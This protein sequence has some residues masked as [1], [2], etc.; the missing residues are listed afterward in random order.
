MKNPDIRC[1]CLLALALMLP[2]L[3]PGAVLATTVRMH[4]TL[5]DI[6][7]QLMDTS[8]PATVANFLNYVSAG[9]YSN[10]FIH[11]GIPGFIVQGGGFRW[12]D[13]TT[14]VS[15]IPANL[16]VINEYSAARSNLRGT[17]AMAKLG[18]DPNSATN[19]WFFNLADN[20]ANLDS[21][22]G[23]F[24]V[25]G[26][27]SGNG[28]QVVDA[29][30]ALPV[31][32]AGGNFANLPLA[33]TPTGGAIS[34][35]NLVMI[36]GISV[37]PEPPGNA[38]SVVGGWNL[39]GNG[40]SDPIAVAN[41]FGDSSLVSTVWKWIPSGSTWAFYSPSLGDGGAAYATSKGYAF[42][43]TINAGEGFWV[44]AKGGFAVQ[45]SGSPVQT[46]S[47]A[48]RVSGNALPAGWSLIAA[49]A[50]LPPL[51]FANTIARTPPSAGT[52]VAT[53]LASLWTWDAAQSGWYFFAPSLVNA[54]TQANYITSKG[55]LDFG[56]KT[57]TPT[58]GFWVNHP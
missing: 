12:D 21:Q 20:A 34:G 46:S 10:T 36:T 28:M 11:R 27:L 37:L 24:T 31:T 3:L 13:A 9:A 47:F 38:L 16:P 30:A 29:I 39:L 54:G 52:T 1:V 58:T 17:I 22:N 55:Y 44:N 41:V 51:A 18:S 33:G 32:N 8:A 49:G 6:D 57:L 56:T 4:T 2:G 5:G 26:Q 14:I 7:V 19:Q 53:S 48:D 40:M 25:F 15:G 50:D 35:K 42:L 43:S 45:L 23:G